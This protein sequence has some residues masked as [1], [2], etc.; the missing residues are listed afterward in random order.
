MA[1]TIF[2]IFVMHA[3]SRARV[4]PFIAHFTLR[5]VPGCPAVDR[6][7]TA[8]RCVRACLSHRAC[9]CVMYPLCARSSGALPNPHRNNLICC[10][11]AGG[12]GWLTTLGHRFARLHAHALISSHMHRQTRTQPHS[13]AVIN[14]CIIH[15]VY[16]T[17]RMG[18]I[19][20]TVYVYLCGWCVFVCVYL[21]H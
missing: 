18:D 14:H 12:D 11:T 15:R 17:D 19:A 20:L 7:G 5:S 6:V 16:C 10:A 1:A 13:P 8:P 2:L 4:C 3:C 9:V 21:T